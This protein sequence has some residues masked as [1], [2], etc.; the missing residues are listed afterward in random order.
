MAARRKN[1]QRLPRE[2]CSP[3]GTQDWSHRGKEM[4]P[5]PPR[6]P[7]VDLEKITFCQKKES[8]FEVECSGGESALPSSSS[9]RCPCLLRVS[10]AIVSPPEAYRKT[11]RQGPF[12][13]GFS[14]IRGRVRP[15]RTEPATLS[16]PLTA[17]GSEEDRTSL[18]RDPILWYGHRLP[19]TPFGTSAPLCPRGEPWRMTTCP[20]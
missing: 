18:P 16:Y 12:G 9:P 2:S 15:G 11:C 5:R 7:L 6:H 19:A 20:S 13:P 3:G 1:C 17:V 14:K 10:K 4:R 8:S